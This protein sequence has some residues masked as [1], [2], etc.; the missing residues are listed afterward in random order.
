MLVTGFADTVAQ[1]LC[2]VS[3]VFFVIAVTSGLGSHARHLAHADVVVAVWAS[4]VSQITGILATVTGKLSI[5]AFL[6]QIRGRHRGRPW[7]LY[8]IAATNVAVN[9]IV[10]VLILVQCM[11]LEK[12]WDQNVPGH[13]S[14]R[15]VNNNY[16]FFQGGECGILPRP[17]HLGSTNW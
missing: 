16:A 10:V 4:W 15:P 3:Q 2:V 13:C 1:V 11:P 5:V 14:L 7:L 6:C 17:P 12:L 9:A 8:A